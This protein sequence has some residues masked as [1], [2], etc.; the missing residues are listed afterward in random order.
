MSSASPGNLAGLRVLVVESLKS[1][2]V[3]LE[4]TLETLGISQVTTAATGK[5]A[6]QYAE[7]QKPDLVLC[8]VNLEEHGDGFDAANRI[9]ETHAAPLVFISASHD[10][11]AA[12]YALRHSPFGYVSPPFEPQRLGAAIGDALYKFRKGIATI[13]NLRELAITEPL[14]GLGTRHKMDIAL[15]HEWN[16]CALE[17]SPLALLLINLDNL[18]GF[19]APGAAEEALKKLSAA[20]QTH[21]ARRRDVVARD[22]PAR[23]IVLLPCTDEPGAQHVAG[24]IVEAIRDLR[25]SPPDSPNAPGVTAAVGIAVAVP[26]WDK[27]ASS[28]VTWAELQLDTAERRGG[29]RFH[30]GSM[31]NADPPRPKGILARWQSLWTPK[32]QDQRESH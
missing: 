9:C 6:V 10:P 15:Y 20:M 1:F 13:E 16:R 29:D 2:A 19:E 14:T 31:Q 28:L 21:C 17:G 27:T 7:E 32:P 30:G 18:D 4:D 12:R 5:E 22:G 24:Q 3:D 26:S 23:C 11:D 25:L 8:D